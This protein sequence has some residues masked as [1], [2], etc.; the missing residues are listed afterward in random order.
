MSNNEA[1][2]QTPKSHKQ[3]SLQNDTSEF[4]LIKLKIQV[5]FMQKT[6]DP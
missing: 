5:D 2:A 3:L 1:L 4:L 6:P